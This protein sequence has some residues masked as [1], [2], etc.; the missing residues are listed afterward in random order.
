MSKNYP[1]TY[2]GTIFSDPGLVWYD[3]AQQTA[4]L[5]AYYPYAESGVPEEFSVAL[6]QRAGCEESDLLGGRSGGMSLP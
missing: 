4:T 2:D 5:T 1:M 3:D 6:D